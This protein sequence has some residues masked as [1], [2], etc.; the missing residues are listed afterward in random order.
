[1]DGIKILISL[2]ILISTPWGAKADSANKRSPVF[3]TIQ[4]FQDGKNTDYNGRKEVE[5]IIKKGVKNDKLK[6]KCSLKIEKNS[7]TDLDPEYWEMVNIVCDLNGIR[8]ETETGGCVASKTHLYDANNKDL[9][10]GTGA[11]RTGIHV[12]CGL[13]I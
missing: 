4:V 13:L 9:Y 7:R 12:Q 2:C 1:M 6:L 11:N 8:V 5:Q 3:W 10:F